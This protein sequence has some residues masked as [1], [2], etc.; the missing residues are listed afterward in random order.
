MATT[1]TDRI[2]SAKVYLEPD[3]YTLAQQQAKKEDETLSNWIRKLI[4]AELLKREVLTPDV[5]LKIATG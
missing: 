3:I 1:V 4:L 2:S 5:I